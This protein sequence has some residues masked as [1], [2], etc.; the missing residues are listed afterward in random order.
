MNRRLINQ[1]LLFGALLAL[2]FTPTVNAE[3]IYDPAT[4]FA[5]TENPNGVWSYHFSND[6]I[7]D[8]SYN[9]MP[10]VAPIIGNGS[11]AWHADAG[12][13]T[14]QR[15]FVAVNT[16]ANIG[17]WTAGDLA[18]HPG[19]SAGGVGDS[20]AV[21]SWT[22]PYT[23][24]AD[25]DYQFELGLSGDVTWYV[26]LNDDSQ[27]LAT[28]SLIGSGANASVQL[29]DISVSVGDR[30]SFVVQSN[31]DPGSDL[32]R[33]TTSTL[34]IPEPSSLILVALSAVQVARFRR[35]VRRQAI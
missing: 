6:V 10:E 2:T 12:A 14:S 17:T 1:N 35:R 25:L 28:G 29:N 16:G 15:P 34:S 24:T 13:A 20:L 9:L 22:S 23:T 26:E 5:T 33:F 31:G 21:L 8:G 11:L 32:V 19:Q 7:R 3:I 30:L 18:V 27:T 4:Q